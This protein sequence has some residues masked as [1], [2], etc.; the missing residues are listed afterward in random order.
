MFYC[1]SKFQEI[2]STL[3]WLRGFILS[4]RTK[5]Q[6]HTQY[7]FIIAHIKNAKKTIENARIYDQRHAC[8]FCGELCSKIACHLMTKHKVECQV[9]EALLHKKNSP[10][11]KKRLT[12]LRLRGD[13]HFNMTTLETGEGELIVV[14]RPGQGE[15]CT[16]NDFLP[17]EY[18]LGFMKN[19]DL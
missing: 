18:C 15:S 10:E 16:I 8:F 2:W 19:W 14:R 6:K 12:K 17:C 7:H 5:Y 9:A 13:Y 1:C 3:I 11:R 4:I